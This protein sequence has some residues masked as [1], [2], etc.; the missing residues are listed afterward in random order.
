MACDEGQ[1]DGAQAGE[2]T[3][4]R[5]M[6]GSAPKNS[7]PKGWDEI[8]VLVVCGGIRPRGALPR[9][10]WLGPGKGAAKGSAW[11]G[12]RLRPDRQRRRPPQRANCLQQVPFQA[13]CR[14]WPC[15]WD[16]AVVHAV[17]CEEYQEEN[18]PGDADG[19]HADRGMSLSRS[20]LRR[21]TD[22]DG[23]VQGVKSKSW[24]LTMTNPRR[25][26][27]GSTGHRTASLDT[28]LLRANSL[29]RLSRAATWK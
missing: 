21:P 3:S 29:P 26:T 5:G 12:R 17:S 24:Q 8:Q 9:H 13:A 15:R 22:L 27:Y 4:M 10:A 20:P 18:H 6:R 11:Q 23:G 28:I 19:A 2:M 14:T 7:Q 1:M 25:D 16:A